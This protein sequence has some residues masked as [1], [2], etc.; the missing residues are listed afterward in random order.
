MDLIDLRTTRK[1]LDLLNTS[2]IEGNTPRYFSFGL[3]EPCTGN[4]QRDTTHKF[5]QTT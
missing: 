3:V 4:E 5:N 2:S 1:E